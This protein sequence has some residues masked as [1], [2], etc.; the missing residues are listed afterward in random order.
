LVVL[1]ARIKLGIE[2][3]G[4]NVVIKGLGD[5]KCGYTFE[6]F[7]IIQSKQGDPKRR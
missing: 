2:R 7:G 5:P 1:K 3:R 4:K 6:P